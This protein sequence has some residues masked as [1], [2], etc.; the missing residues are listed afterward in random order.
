MPR[1][2]M[3]SFVKLAYAYPD[4]VLRF[5]LMTAL[6]SS[7]EAF[8]HN[9]RMLAERV[10]KETGKRLDY[11]GDRHSLSHPAL[12]PDEEA[13]RVLFRSEALT[14]EGRDI[15]IGMVETV[16]DAITEQYSLSLDL[17]TRNVFM[18]R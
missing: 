13:D 18:V 4:P 14:A 1:R 12:E 15:A 6:E 5:W 9:T 3:A 7:G 2:N 11:L 10:E 16:F 8:F 17:A